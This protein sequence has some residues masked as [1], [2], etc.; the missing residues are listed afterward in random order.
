MKNKLLMLCSAGKKNSHSAIHY[1]YDIGEGWTKYVCG[2][3]GCISW[4][5]QYIPKASLIISKDD[6][7]VR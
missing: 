5:K 1:I 6:F 2:Y 7:D 3:C 4:T